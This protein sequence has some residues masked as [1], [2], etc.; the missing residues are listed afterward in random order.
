[1]TSLVFAT[2]LP[3]VSSVAIEAARAEEMIRNGLFAKQNGGIPADWS[4]RDNEQEVTIDQ[5]DAKHPEIGQALRVGILSDGGSSY[6][7]IA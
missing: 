7:Q 3:V 6:G 5:A 1:M 2:L 4:I